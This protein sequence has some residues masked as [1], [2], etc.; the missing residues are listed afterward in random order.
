MCKSARLPTFIC[1]CSVQRHKHSAFSSTFPIYLFEKWT[2]EVPDESEE[3]ITEQKKIPEPEP[4][5]ESVSPDADEA[6]V[7]DVTKADEGESEVPPP[8]KMVNVTKEVWTRLNSQP[9][10]WAR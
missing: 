9:P 6:T 2:E 4:S 10:L 3:P 1:L 7:E 8:P 5:L